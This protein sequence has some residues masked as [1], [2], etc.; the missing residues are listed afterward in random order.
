[1]GEIAESK[2]AN[3]D[4]EV[5]SAERNLMCKLAVL[6]F[7][8]Y[9]GFCVGIYSSQVSIFRDNLDISDFVL[10]IITSFVALGYICAAPVSAGL[11]RSF[12]SMWIA[13]FGSQFYGVN[14]SVVGIVGN[15][16]GSNAYVLG[17]ALLVFGFTMGIMDIAGNSQGILVE[18]LGNTSYFGL[19][20]GTYAGAVAVGTILGGVLLFACGDS[21]S[22][23]ICIGSGI[24]FASL[25]FPYAKSRLYPYRVERHIEKNKFN[26][27]EPSSNDESVSNCESVGTYYL[28]DSLLPPGSR[29]DETSDTEKD[30]PLIQCVYPTGLLRLYC[31]TGFLGSFA[32][33]ITLAT[34]RIYLY[35]K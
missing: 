15:I 29:P 3:D 6:Y 33:G 18:V 10:G 25:A 24:V 13:L 2:P 35:S 14:F 7:F 27:S 12:G 30:E 28:S 11:C 20:H 21:G 5:P 4:V 26:T 1:M 17:T 32:E 34:I 9:Q 23:Y 16:A 19:F 31:L 22:L 8:V